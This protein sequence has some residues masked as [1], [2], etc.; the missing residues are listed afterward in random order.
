MKLRSIN[1]ISRFDF[2]NK[3]KFLFL[4]YGSINFLITN[5]ILQVT[6]LCISTKYATLISQLFNLNFGFY[7]YGMRVFKV[8]ILKKNYY[9]KYL[10][11][12]I[13]IWIINWILI[14][15]INS[16]NI[17]KNLAALFVLPLLA[18]ISF[19][20]QKKIVFTE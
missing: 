16:Y 9:L 1:K 4:V 18:L 17:S 14:N 2:R 11:F 10:V 3:K 19:V 20:Y 6:L 7:S 5:L 15:F 12:H 8:K 13:F